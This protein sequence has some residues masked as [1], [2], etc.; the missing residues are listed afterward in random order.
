MLRGE[1]GNQARELDQLIDWL[2]ES[3]PK[4]DV[5]CLSNAL[6]LGLARRLKSQLGCSVVCSLQGEDSFLDALPPVH[7]AA[8][9]QL[10][11]ERAREVE[12]FISP[13][14][15]FAR[16]ISERL[17]LPSNRVHVVHNGIDLSGFDKPV[18]SGKRQDD[19]PVLGFF[20]RMCREKGLD[21]LIEAFIILRKAGRQLA[22]RI[23]G[24]CGPA[25][26]IFVESLRERLRAENL[27]SEVEFHPNLDRA[28]KLAFLRGLT[29]FSVPALY[30][31]AYGLYVIE[32]M[33]AGVPVVQPN[34]AAFPEIIEATGGG[35]LCAPGDSR[36][37]A[38]AIEGLLVNPERAQALGFAGANSVFEKFSADSMA[39]ACVE[40]F[41]GL[42]ARI[43]EDSP[44]VKSSS[45]PIQP[46][47]AA[48]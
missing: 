25:D 21:S 20:A 46:S 11:A 48:K 19:K 30:G 32:A 31:E 39:R 45:L 36:K 40:V 10:L 28:G 38:E 27:L 24:S 35:V 6:L 22:L 17:G 47:S 33:A 14:R 7:R 16:V 9:W 43:S 8:C 3:Q 34:T 5:V 4:P 13:S 41:E 44:A 23:G 12:G 2:L 29:V 1:E 18:S 15:Y 42:R 37:L 26:R